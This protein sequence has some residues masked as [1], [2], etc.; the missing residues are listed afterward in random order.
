MRKCI[1]YKKRHFLCLVLQ[2]DH[3]T[4]HVVQVFDMALNLSYHAISAPMLI[5]SL[6]MHAVSP[7]ATVFFPIPSS[8]ILDWKVFTIGRLSTPAVTSHE[9]I[10]AV[11]L[12]FGARAQECL[13]RQNLLFACGTSK[14]LFGSSQNM[15]GSP[16]DEIESLFHWFI[17]LYSCLNTYFRS[18]N[19]NNLKPDLR[20]YAEKALHK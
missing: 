18:W 10:T 16:I 5:F 8:C 2:E 15:M 17:L 3:L 20:I 7:L 6:Q 11:L 14:W 9:G 12:L 13:Q 4:G 19:P 1:W